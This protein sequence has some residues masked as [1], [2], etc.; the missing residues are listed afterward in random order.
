MVGG[1]WALL[2][3]VRC[4]KCGATSAVQVWVSDEPTKGEC[5]L[6]IGRLLLN[7]R[8]ACFNC[9]GF[10]VFFSFLGV[11]GVVCKSAACCSIAGLGVQP[12]SKLS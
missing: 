8:A 10:G 5:L 9:K 2:Q 6:L 11:W 1:G 7:R 4:D 12:A 3:Q